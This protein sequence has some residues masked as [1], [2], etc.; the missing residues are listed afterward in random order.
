[1]TMT[2]TVSPVAIACALLIPCLTPYGASAQPN[3]SPEEVRDRC[4]QFLSDRAT[5][6]VEKNSAFL[7][8]QSQKID[9]ARDQD[10]EQRVRRIIRSSIRKM[11]AKTKRVPRKL[12]RAARNCRRLIRRISDDP[13]LADALIT[14]VNLS[15]ENAVEAITT[16]GQDTIQ[17]FKD[18]RDGGS[19]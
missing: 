14:D 17:T 11:K 19:E 6:V 5:Q 13:A 16:S 2:K 7:E 1:M 12:R 18:K 9:E 8:K 3:A 15:L 4:V 10:K